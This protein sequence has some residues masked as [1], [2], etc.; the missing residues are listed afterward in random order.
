MSN[1]A[2]LEA[3]DRPSRTSQPQSRTKMRWSRRKDTDD[4]D[5]L[6][7]DPGH[8]RRQGTQTS[9]TPQA[10]QDRVLVAEHQDLGVLE[11]LVPGQHRQAAEQTMHEQID[12]RNDH[13]TM[14]PAVKSAEARS[15]N[16]A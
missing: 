5:G 8:R 15:S 13:S 9:G 6:T 11:Y 7:A 1:S 3:D 14:I 2:S 16:R 10:A 12:N 4:H